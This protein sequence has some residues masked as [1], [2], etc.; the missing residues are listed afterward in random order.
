[1]LLINV[2]ANMRSRFQE[3]CVVLWTKEGTVSG[4]IQG[5]NQLE[6]RLKHLKLQCHVWP[7]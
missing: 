6:N 4:E 5:K 1:V 3:E 2:T 7:G